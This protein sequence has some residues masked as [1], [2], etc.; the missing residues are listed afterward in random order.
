MAEIIISNSLGVVSERV[1]HHFLDCD[2]FFFFFFFLFTQSL[3]NLPV[4]RFCYMNEWNPAERTCVNNA[5]LNGS[6]Q[7]RCTAADAALV[8]KILGVQSV[9]LTALQNTTID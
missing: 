9:S 4:Y 1:L 8:H 5:E 2:S 3:F 7:R 6:S